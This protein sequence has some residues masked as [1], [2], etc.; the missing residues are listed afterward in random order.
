MRNKSTLPRFVKLFAC[1]N[2]ILLPE[3]RIPLN[4]F[5]EQYCT[6]V[7][8]AIQSSNRMI[9]VIQNSGDDDQQVDVGCLGRIVSFSEFSNERRYFVVIRGEQRFRIAERIRHQAGY[10]FARVSYD[11][12]GQDLQPTDEQESIDKEFWGKLIK[13]Y[14]KTVNTSIDEEYLDNFHSVNF[15]NGLSVIF[16][17]EHSEKQALLEAKDMAERANILRFIMEANILKKFDGFVH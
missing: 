4:I 1:D 11:E 17:F 2:V 5:E 3:C 9:G 13:N 8:H 16:P 10:Q 14:L 6:M 7:E 15:I 12:F